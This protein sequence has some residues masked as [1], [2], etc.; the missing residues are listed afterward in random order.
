METKKI[1]INKVPAIIWGGPSEKI[2]LYIHGQ[3]G[4]KEEAETF[5]NIA[6]RH[7]WQVLSIDLPEHGERKQESNTFVPWCVVPELLSV[8]E[9]LKSKWSHISLF[10][11]SIGAWFSMLSF[12]D[13]QLEESLFVSPVLNM[14]QLIV[15]MMQWA[16]VSEERLKNEL[17]IP[18]SFGQTLSW[19]Y[20]MYAKNHPINRW[21]VATKIL[22]GSNDNLIER[23][24]VERFAHTFNCDLT[25]MENGE[26]WFHTE[27][28]LSVLYDWVESCFQAN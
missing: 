2:Y 28:Q 27:R 8:M 5:A 11:N 22:Y 20:L 19:E 7:S 3:G 10:A 12:E 9:F 15:T 17:V 23:N 25:V 6:C 18:T 21:K 26:H 13:K 24:V 14:K 4:Y 16:N 1:L